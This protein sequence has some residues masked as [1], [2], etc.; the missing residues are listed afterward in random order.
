MVFK[1]IVNFS[2]KICVESTTDKKLALRN[3][4]DE[5]SFKISRWESILVCGSLL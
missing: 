2:G 1:I 3:F 4:G 5:R